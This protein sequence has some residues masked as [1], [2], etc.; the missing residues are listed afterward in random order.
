[1]VKLVR[2]TRPA[3]IPTLLKIKVSKGYFCSDAIVEP[4]KPLKL[5]SDLFL[6]E[7]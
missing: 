5:F 6:K 3:S 7:P 4:K 2:A 1:M